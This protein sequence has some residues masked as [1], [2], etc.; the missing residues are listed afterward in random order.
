MIATAN[1]PNDPALPGLA[2]IDHRWQLLLRGYKPGCYATLEARDGRQHVVIKVFANDPSEEAAVY[3]ALA[4]AGAPV[5]RLLAWELA[6][7]TL[8]LSWLD[9]PS[10]HVLVRA[11]HGQRAGKLAASW[12]RGV[13]KLPVRLGPPFGTA[14]ML[15]RVQKWV[16]AMGA[17]DP[18][19]GSLAAELAGELV[20]TQPPENGTRLVHGSFHDRNLL[21][22]GDGPGVID[23]QRFGQG[24]AEIEAGKFLASMSRDRTDE[25]AR[26]IVAFRAGTAGLFNERALAW[27]WAAAVFSLA[28][29]PLTHRRDGWQER[30]RPQLREASDVVAGA[31]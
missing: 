31:S 24:P 19:L 25:A 30:V 16:A 1:L 3:I 18:A 14:H 22:L 27:H 23:W 6:S 21:D 5:P 20:R 4:E 13:A 29:R 2:A 7:R 12:L 26:A 8:V 9:G 10:A 28:D 15:R 17:A 11:G